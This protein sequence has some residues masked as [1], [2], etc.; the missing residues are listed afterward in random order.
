M[1]LHSNA[2]ERRK[3]VATK[4]ERELFYIPLGMDLMPDASQ[5]NE[6]T[7]FRVVPSPNI[8]EFLWARCSEDFLPCFCHSPMFLMFLSLK[9]L[10]VSGPERLKSLMFLPSLGVLSLAKR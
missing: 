9:M 6:R 1:V 8:C 5:K 4:K 7:L 3:T 2:Q 10:Y